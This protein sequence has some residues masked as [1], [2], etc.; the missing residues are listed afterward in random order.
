MGMK[1]SGVVLKDKRSLMSLPFLYLSEPKVLAS[2]VLRG[3]SP[4][5]SSKNQSVPFHSPTTYFFPNHSPLTPRPLSRRLRNKRNKCI[6][7][8]L[9]IKL[10][11]NP[12]WPG[13]TMKLC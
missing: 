8:N 2:V 4:S 5:I 13:L 1:A 3:C 6:F 11:V 10:I 12:L 9:T 7:I